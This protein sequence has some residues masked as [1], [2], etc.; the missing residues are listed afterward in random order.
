PERARESRVV[1]ASSDGSPA[2]CEAA[3]ARLSDERSLAAIAMTAAHE[4]IRHAALARTT[5]DRVLRDVVRNAADPMIRR[6]ALARIEDPKILQSIA[7]ADGQTELALQALERTTDATRRGAWRAVGTK[8]RRVG[9]PCRRTSR[10][11]PLSA[12]ASKGSMTPPHRVPSTTRLPH[13]TASSPSPTNRSQ[14]WHDAS[15]WAARRRRR[16]AS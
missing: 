4:S 2:E 9:V 3:L 10:R 6:A 7:V 8:P 1:V 13:G 14:P 16:A 11:V 12:S 15:S 5:G